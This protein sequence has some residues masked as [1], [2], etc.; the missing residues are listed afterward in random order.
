MISVGNYK[1][2]ERELLSFTLAVTGGQAVILSTD[3]VKSCAF[4]RDSRPITAKKVAI[5]ARS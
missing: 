5:A 4:S 2:A 1:T 3:R